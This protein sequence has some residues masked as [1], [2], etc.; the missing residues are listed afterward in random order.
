MSLEDAVEQ[1]SVEMVEKLIKLGAN[2]DEL[3]GFGDTALINASEKGYIKIVKILINKNANVNFQNIWGSNALTWASIGGHV[4]IVIELINA[5][6]DVNLQDADDETALMYACKKNKLEVIKE[7]LKAN[8][9]VNDKIIKKMKKY[10][11]DILK[12]LIIKNFNAGLKYAIKFNKQ[13]DI[14]YHISILISNYLNQH[15]QYEQGLIAII[16]NYC[17]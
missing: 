2:V 7:L 11:I 6:A 17:A 1:N 15:C 13:K 4:K 5:G 9:I 3:N 12:L 10:D 16:S 14:K 8:A